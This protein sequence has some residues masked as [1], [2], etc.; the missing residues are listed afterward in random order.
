MKDWRNFLRFAGRV[1][2]IHTITYFIFGIIFSNLFN[3]QELFNLKPI[4]GFM[5][6]ID[7]PW[8]I[9]GPF[10][11]PLRGLMFAIAL[12]P[13]RQLFIAKK[14]GWLLIWGLFLAFGIIGP[15]AAAPCSIEGAIYT[16]LPLWYHLLGL[17]EIMLQTLAFSL[18]LFAW[19]RKNLRAIHNSRAFVIACYAYIGYAAG[20]LLTLLISSIRIIPGSIAKIEI[21]STM[22]A[23]FEA[24]AGNIRLQLMFV[25]AFI[26]NAICIYLF[27]R[28]QE[29]TAVSNWF[30]FLFFLAVDTLVPFFYQSIILGG[31]PAFHYSLLIGFFPAVIIW[32]N[33]R[34]KGVK[35]NG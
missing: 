5:R 7:S 34:T 22:N 8:V 1:T 20:S 28:Q 26:V 18:V 2:L 9:A 19:E 6:S 31:V 29:K 21:A 33:I 3:Y 25:V 30:L 13:L 11:Q 27:S 16:K 10:L 35:S 17:P 23:G 4:S 12:W 14:D 32:L 24:A 15:P